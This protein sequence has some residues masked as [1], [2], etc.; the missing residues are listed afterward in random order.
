MWFKARPYH[1]ELDQEYVEN[2]PST[3]PA[4]ILLC[5]SSRRGPYIDLRIYRAIVFLFQV[6]SQYNAGPYANVLSGLHDRTAE[7]RY[8]QQ[9]GGT[10]MWFDQDPTGLLEPHGRPAGDHRHYHHGARPA[11][12]VGGH[13]TDGPIYG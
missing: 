13:R 8:R 3:S 4:Y 9:M 7:E 6:T 1:L 12:G 11:W 5:H 2:R 10:I